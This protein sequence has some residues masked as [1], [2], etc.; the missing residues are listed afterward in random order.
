VPAI[1]NEVWQVDK[2][3]PVTHVDEMTRVVADSIGSRWF[4]FVLIAIFGTFAVTLAAIGIYGVLS[5]AVAQRTREIGIRLALGASRGSVIGA[6]V[7]QAGVLAGIGSIAGVAAAWLLVPVLRAVL[8]GVAGMDPRV[9]LG[10]VL[11][12][13]AVASAASLIPA[14]RAARLDPASSLR[15]D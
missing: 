11:V 8:Y 4:Q 12:L 9:F 2:N 3:Q 6:I 10:A 1:K 13:L 7:R 5:Y 14:F 15:G